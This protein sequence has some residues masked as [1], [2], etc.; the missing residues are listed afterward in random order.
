MTTIAVKNATKKSEDGEA[1]QWSGEGLDAKL[2]QDEGWILA[3]SMG[4]NRDFSGGP[5]LRAHV[6]TDPNNYAIAYPSD[7]L[8][9][10]EKGHVTVAPNDVFEENYDVSGDADT[11]ENDEEEAEV[12]EYQRHPTGEE[13]NIREGMGDVTEHRLEPDWKALEEIAAIADGEDEAAAE[14]ATEQISIELAELGVDVETHP[15][16]TWLEMVATT[17]A[18]YEQAHAG[19]SEESGEESE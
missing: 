12:P 13:P 3:A 5:V 8:V 10:D 6:G 17:Q 4:D 18:D 14:T 7:W 1:V 15:A 16:E 9:K 2:L 19:T 11:L